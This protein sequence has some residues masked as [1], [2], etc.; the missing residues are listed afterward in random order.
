VRYKN[1]LHYIIFECCS[2]VKEPEWLGNQ[3]VQDSTIC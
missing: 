2:A 3:T 1:N